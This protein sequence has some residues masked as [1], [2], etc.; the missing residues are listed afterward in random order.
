MVYQSIS[1]FGLPY[2]GVE[3]AAVFLKRQGFKVWQFEPVPWIVDLALCQG[4]LL[5]LIAARDDVRLDRGAEA[6]VYKHS[7]EGLED[8]VQERLAELK[9]GVHLG[10]LSEPRLGYV[11]AMAQV[12][13][14]N[15]HDLG[16][17]GLGGFYHCLMQ[18]AAGL[19]YPGFWSLVPRTANPAG[20]PSA[21][22]GVAQYQQVAMEA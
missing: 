14:H 12:V 21:E 18:L 22:I 15:N 13:I 2:S 20:L 1:L 6:G 9:G 19:T 16:G 11:E 3:F 7:E 4:D 8:R 10:H 5:V 17:H